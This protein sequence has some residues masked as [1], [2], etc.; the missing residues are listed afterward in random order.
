L[1]K[2]RVEHRLK[3][4]ETAL[5]KSDASTAPRVGNNTLEIPLAKGVSL[6]FRL[7][8]PGRFLM[9]SKKTLVPITK[10]F[11]IGVTEVT[12][13]Q[14]Q[15]VMDNNPSRYK[16]DLRKP[17]E[18]VSLDECQKFIAVLNNSRF[19]KYRFRLPAEAE[20]EYACRAGTTTR[21]HYGD[22][23]RQLVQYAWSKQIRAA[24]HIQ[25]LP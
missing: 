19:G 18:M 7:I 22:D 16:G 2:T 15:V 3:E 10:P 6:N 17:V 23:L 1:D 13:A 20:W 12:Q 24:G 5:A 14:W 9:G 25:W 21:Y 11:Y 4:I 8:P